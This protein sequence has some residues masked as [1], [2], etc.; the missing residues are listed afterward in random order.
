[1]KKQQPVSENESRLLKM[2]AELGITFIDLKRD[3]A[4]KWTFG[5][6]GHEELLLL[7]LDVFYLTHRS[8][9]CMML[10]SNS[11]AGTIITLVSI[12]ITDYPD[13]GRY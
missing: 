10:K 2:A 13:I 12:R 7:L 11:N 6:Q 4:F 5:T 1:M 9:S 3:F 8:N